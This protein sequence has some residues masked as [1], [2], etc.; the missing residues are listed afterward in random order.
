[1]GPQ[2]EEQREEEKEEIDLDA[3]IGGG[4]FR[5][6]QEQ[7]PLFQNIFE[8]SLAKRQQ[9]VLNSRLADTMSYFDIRDG[10]LYRLDK[11]KGGNNI[12]QILVPRQ[13]WM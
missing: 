1:M 8:E 10:I 5:E 6:H 4:H 2:G 13:Y 9:E 11:G 3:I 7:E 12:L